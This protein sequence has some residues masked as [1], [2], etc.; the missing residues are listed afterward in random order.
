MY[1]S[2][3]SVRQHKKS[4]SKLT[5]PTIA[6]IFSFEGVEKIWKWN[7][8]FIKVRVLLDDVK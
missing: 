1:I 2:I 7:G 3:K 5:K 6:L 8:W 4:K